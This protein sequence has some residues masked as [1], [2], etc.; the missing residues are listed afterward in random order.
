MGK[1]I[2]RVFPSKT[3]ATPTDDLVRIRALPTLRDDADEVHISVAFSWDKAWAEQAARFWS[4]VAP[5]KVGGPAYNEPGGEFVPGMYMKDGYVI[6]S[7]GC[8]NRG[9]WFC[10]VPKREGGVLRELPVRD[11]WILTDDNLLACSPGHIDAVFGMLARQPEKPQFVGGL[12]AA[13]LTPEMARR[14]RSLKPKSLF[15]AYD[16]PNDLAPLQAAGRMLLDAGFTRSSNVLGC[17]VL[18]GYRGDTQEKVLKRMEEAWRA[19]FFP[20]G[21]LYRDEAGQRPQDWIQFQREW[22][23]H[24]TRYGNCQKFKHGPA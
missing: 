14:L 12:E 10:S 23:C 4:V 17:Y 20:M 11:G 2:I 15:M 1:R 7:R 13:L 24:R 19:G 3:N 6:T 22:T 21:M 9:C 8:P 5:T 18:C 16:T